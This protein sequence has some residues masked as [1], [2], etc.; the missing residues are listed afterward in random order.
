[1]AHRLFVYYDPNRESCQARP[2]ETLARP[3]DAS[4]TPPEGEPLPA[5]AFMREYVGPAATTNDYGVCAYLA[6]AA[7]EF[8]DAVAVSCVSPGLNCLI[9]VVEPWVI[10]GAQRAANEV[11]E[12]VQ[13]EQAEQ[14]SREERERAEHRAHEETEARLVREAAER[15]HEA[16]PRCHVP[17]LR[18]H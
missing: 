13:R 10:Q 11:V 1:G 3:G 14:L 5:G 16:R 7:P 17:S 8:Y 9:F 12:R 2:D 18:G 4:V 15:A 6:T